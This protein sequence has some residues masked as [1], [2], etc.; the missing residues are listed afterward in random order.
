MSTQDLLWVG[1]GAS[2]ALALVAGIAD[3]RRNR[4]GNIDAVGW[5]PWRGMHL[6]AI[7]AALACA[8]LALR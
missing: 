5:V 2:A 4:R 1:A 7:A 8:F 6:V 3:W